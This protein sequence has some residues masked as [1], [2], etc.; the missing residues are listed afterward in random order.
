MIETH[1]DG[2]S[3]EDRLRLVFGYDTHAEFEYDLGGPRT[4]NMT[5]LMEDLRRGQLIEAFAFDVWDGSGWHEMGRGTT[6]GWKKFLRFLACDGGQ[7]PSAYPEIER[8]FGDLSSGQTYRALSRS[9]PLNRTASPRSGTR[10][11]S[12]IL[13]ARPAIEQ[14]RNKGQGFMSPING[15]C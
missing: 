12:P 11:S 9:R 10:N 3:D 7:G 13:G 4:F 1:A 14:G 5:M 8:A 2:I 15:S 6:V